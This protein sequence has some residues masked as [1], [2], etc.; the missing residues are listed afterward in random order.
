MIF[1]AMTDSLNCVNTPWQAYIVLAEVPKVK[2][3]VCDVDFKLIPQ[4][5]V[6]LNELE[7]SGIVA[8]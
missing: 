3:V 6:G 4:N 1:Q 5:P 7:R 8:V 2:A